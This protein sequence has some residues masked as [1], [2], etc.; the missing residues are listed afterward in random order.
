MSTPKLVD[1]VRAELH[2]VLTYV[3]IGGTDSRA[4]R[5]AAR[6]HP[7]TI[8]IRVHDPRLI[9]HDGPC[10][11]TQTKSS[12]SDGHLWPRRADLCGRL[13]WEDAAIPFDLG[14]EVNCSARVC[15]EP[16]HPASR[17]ESVNRMVRRS[18]VD[19]LDSYIRHLAQRTVYPE[20]SQ[21]PRVRI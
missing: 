11:D 5:I 9:Q 7:C 6:K 21:V 15:E 19:R 16:G 12:G 8:R 17:R 2:H 10:V 20:S 3:L 14:R 1:H 18:E 13:R 4:D